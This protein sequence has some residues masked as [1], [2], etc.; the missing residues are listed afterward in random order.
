MSSG[1]IIGCI[2]FARDQLLRMEELA[3]GASANFVHHLRCS[4]RTSINGG[5]TYHRLVLPIGF[6]SFGSKDFLG[7]RKECQWHFAPKICS[8]FFLWMR[9]A[10]TAVLSYTK[11]NTVASSSRRCSFLFGPFAG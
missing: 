3:I 8:K 4:R 11:N 2:L 7:E 1:E 9:A 5:S 6:G 10:M